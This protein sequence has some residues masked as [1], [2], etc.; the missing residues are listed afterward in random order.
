MTIALPA[1]PSP[2]V[3]P[4][5]ALGRKLALA[6]IGLVSFELIV[7]GVVSSWLNYREAR[8]TAVRLQREKAQSAAERINFFVSEIENQIGWTTRPDWGSVGLDQRRYDFI[9]LLRQAPAITELT[10]VDA[11]GKEQLRLSRLEPD[12]IDGGKDLSADPRFSEAAANKIWFSPVTFR[13]GSEPYMTIATAQAAKKPGVVIAD[14]N[15]KLIWDAVSAIRVGESGNAYVVDARGKLIAHPDISLVLRET[16]LSA[17]PQ[18]AAALANPNPEARDIHNI[19]GDA[20]EGGRVLT[21][22]AAIPRLGWTVFVQQPLRE[23][24]AP[25]YASLIETAALLGLGL[26]LASLLGLYLARRIVAPIALLQAGAQRLGAGDLSQRLSVRTGDEIEA[27]AREFN[28]MADQL[29][30]YTTG[31]QQKVAAKTAELELA[32]RHKSEFLANMSHELRTPLN[33]V[34]GFSDALKERMFGELNAK[35]MEYVGDINA[36]GQHLLSLIN[37]ILDL[38]KIEAGRMELDLRRFDVASALENCRTLIRE[39]AHRQGLTLDFEVAPGLGTWKADERK[40]KQIV[41]NLLTNAVKFTPAGGRVKVA[42]SNG[43]DWLEVSVDDTGPGIAPADHQTI[44]EEFRQLRTHGEAKN[45]GTGLGLALTRRLVEL[46]GGAIEL[47][48]DVGRGARFVV[49]L[50]REPSP[51]HG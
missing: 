30:E 50:P 44:F 15:L 27:L 49:R 18:V 28:L 5:R 12:I 29:Q 16:D 37:D 45:E 19:V 2:N 3:P 36:S 34:I 11:A 9:R 22:H 8:A 20:P 31:L 23:A 46:H 7:E 43:G 6:L 33:A 42:A 1:A 14:V 25:L 51:A 39:R 38:A 35:Q 24:L 47:D 41:L 10:Q 13:H 48:S 32:N 4:R 17:L 26:L 40:F 21:A